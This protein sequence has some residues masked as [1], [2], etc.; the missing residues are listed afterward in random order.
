MTLF[1]RK[2]NYH[3][4]LFSRNGELIAGKVIADSL[5]GRAALNG[6]KGALEA[7]DIQYWAPNVFGILRQSYRKKRKS[8]KALEMLV[9]IIGVVLNAI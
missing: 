3:T 7:R 6:G 1:Y 5:R 8:F 4:G 9:H 2:N